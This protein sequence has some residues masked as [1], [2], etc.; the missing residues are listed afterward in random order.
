MGSKQGSLLKSFGTN[1]TRSLHD[2][3]TFMV[4]GTRRT[5]PVPRRKFLVCHLI[6]GLR[7]VRAQLGL[8]KNF[9][10]IFDFFGF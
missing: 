9:G 8:Q 5:C 4:C 2:D 6:G 7:C 1:C 10:P 3:L